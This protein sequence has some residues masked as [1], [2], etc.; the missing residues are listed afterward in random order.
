MAPFASVGLASAGGQR[1]RTFSGGMKRRLEIARAMLHDPA[2]LVL[3]EP[4]EG[5]DPQTR[6]IVWDQLAAIA[7]THERTVFVTTHYMRTRRSDATTWRSSITASS[8]LGSSPKRAY[9][10]RGWRA[11]G[12]PH[13]TTTRRRGP[14]RRGTVG[15]S[16][17]PGQR[18]SAR[19]SRGIGPKRIPRAFLAERALGIR[20]AAIVKTHAGRCLYCLDGPRAARR[21]RRRRRPARPR[22]PRSH[23]YEPACEGP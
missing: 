10:A 11:L 20:E 4:T 19:S 7:A 6:R 12:P 14:L 23:G 1:V 5:L 21:A 22:R 3:D 17:V 13:R 2:I 18:S 16:A 9:R 8:W 15:W